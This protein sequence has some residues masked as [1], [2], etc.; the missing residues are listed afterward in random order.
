M[1]DINL[2][3][4]SRYGKHPNKL[5]AFTGV[6]VFAFN[7]QAEYKGEWYDLQPLGTEGQGLIPGKNL[8]NKI[9]MNIPFGIGYNIGLGEN[10]Q[11][12]FI[13]TMRKTFTDYIDDVSGNYYDNKK[14]TE[15]RGEL[16][17]ILADRNLQRDSGR[18][19]K[20]GSGR[21][22]PRNNDNFA[23]I[24]IS[25][26]QGLTFKNGLHPFRPKAKRIHKKCPKW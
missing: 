9:S 10:G 20:A 24:Q 4:I 7:P 8:Y 11:I 25:F 26:S 3:T 5:F 21:G 1:A 23:F 18:L 17:G 14:L 19:A 13:L 6:G 2:L 15:E 16:A 12:G 22:D